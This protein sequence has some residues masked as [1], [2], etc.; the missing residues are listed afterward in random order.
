MR[1]APA[2]EALR[3]Y[4]VNVD[5]VVQM[6]WQPLY[7]YQDYAAA[8]SQEFSFFQVP[9]GQAGKTLEDTN[10]TN[11][12]VL[13]MPKEM[14][15]TGMEIFFHSGA[16]VLT[17]DTAAN[18]VSQLEDLNALMGRGHIQIFIGSKAML[19]DVG[20]DQ[21][22]VGTSLDAALALSDSTT[23]AAAALTQVGNAGYR[24]R[25]Y[26]FEPLLIPANQNFNVNINFPNGA[27]TLPSGQDA[28]VGVRL[29]GWQYRLAQ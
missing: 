18:Q 10:M 24:G 3:D 19:D 23:A 16:P 4:E 8:G 28:R 5:N 9:K 25:A 12:G 22:P 1:R 13:P 2:L 11:A 20:I 7:D 6:L 29:L 27:V 14:L 17:Q 26:R 21:F 15:V